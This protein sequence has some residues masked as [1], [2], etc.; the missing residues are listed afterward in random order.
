MLNDIALSFL[1]HERRP[2]ARLPSD[3]RVVMVR[4]TGCGRVGYENGRL[5]ITARESRHEGKAGHAF[6]AR[7][8]RSGPS[9]SEIGS[10][11]QQREDRR[12]ERI[13][14]LVGLDG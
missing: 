10:Q 14:A 3:H 13:K 4:S 11:E 1:L 9:G 8:G 5:E 2:K 12:P 6:R 7:H